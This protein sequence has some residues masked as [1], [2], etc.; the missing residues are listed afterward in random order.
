MRIASF[1]LLALPLAALRAQSGIPKVSFNHAQIFDA[2]CAQ[3][4]R[5]T[6]PDAASRELD[7]LLSGLHARWSKEGPKLLQGVVQITGW[8]FEF[9]EAN[10]AAIL[11]NFGSVSFP[12]IVDMRP[13][14]KSTAKGE[15][16]SE[17]VF[18]TV[19]IHEVL[20]HYVDDRLDAWP[21]GISPLLIKYKDESAVVRNHLHLFAIEKLLYS[22]LRMESYLAESIVSENKL[23]P[24]A[25][26][27]R[28]REIVDRET[29]QAFIKE[30][31]KP[32]RP[33][34]R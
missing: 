11:C 18:E 25:S 28:A 23:G 19:I 33:G 20:H 9:P 3:L 17:A 14:L 16:E 27:R 10:F 2:R 31:T 21:D 29:P 12:P 8:K 32:P 5:D 1:A 24:A 13:F 6:I 30:L 15:V 26:F 34:A 22:R 4:L 7:Q